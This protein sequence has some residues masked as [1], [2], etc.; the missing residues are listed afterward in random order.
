MEGEILSLQDPIIRDSLNKQDLPQLIKYINNSYLDTNAIIAIADVLYRNSKDAEIT[1]FGRKSSYLK[2]RSDAE[3]KT[4]TQII[5]SE[6]KSLLW[7]SLK[8]TFDRQTHIYTIS[9]VSAYI[10]WAL[11]KALNEI[12]NNENY[13]SY[14][15][16]E[17][18]ISIKNKYKWNEEYDLSNYDTLPLNIL[19]MVEYVK[20]NLSDVTKNRF[21][22]YIRFWNFRNRSKFYI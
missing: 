5:A 4:I 19:A 13:Y 17:G 3:E 21:I 20:N 18:F 8:F 11:T 16:A 7:L 15:L 12:R 9:R 2:T 10:G 1:N 14:C 6:N 22:T